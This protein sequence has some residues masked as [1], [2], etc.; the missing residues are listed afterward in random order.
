[1][2]IAEGAGA[3]DCTFDDP[4]LLR[5]PRA[6]QVGD[7]KHHLLYPGTDAVAL[8]TQLRRGRGNREPS[9]PAFCVARIRGADLGIG[10][11]GRRSP[12][13]PHLGLV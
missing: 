11:A 4:F 9:P 2:T 13:E 3:F 12:L 8:E 5:V 10:G 7:S 1:M 6:P